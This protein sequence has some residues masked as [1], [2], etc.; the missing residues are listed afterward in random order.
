M[1]L[2]PECWATPNPWEPKY[3]HLL[4]PD[5]FTER[6]EPHSKSRSPLKKSHIPEYVTF[7]TGTKISFNGLLKSY[8]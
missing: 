6:K 1:V 5:S 7:F 8:L 2:Q 4:T 3:M